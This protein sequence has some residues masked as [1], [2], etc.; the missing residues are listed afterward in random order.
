MRKLSGAT[1]GCLL[2]ITGIAQAEE[3]IKYRFVSHSVGLLTMDAGDGV[4]GHVIGAAK[5]TGIVTLDDGRSGIVTYL[6]NI[7]YVKGSG[8]YTLYQTFKFAD[9][10][11]LRMKAG[12]PAKLNGSKTDF[13]DGK[14]IIVGGEGKYAG[15]SG[16]G[17][18]VGARLAPIGDGGDTLDEGVLHLK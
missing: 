6:S 7:D 4:D 3:T 2:T 12:G 11:V 8:V 10:S 16:D 1:V 14:I 17:E 18:Y 9:G 13:R 5:F 15:A